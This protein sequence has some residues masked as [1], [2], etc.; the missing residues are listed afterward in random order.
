MATAGRI[1]LLL[2]TVLVPWALSAGED[3]TAR[4][5]VS[6][7]DVLV[8]DWINVRVDITHPR[9]TTSQM[10]LGDTLGGYTVLDRS[11]LTQQAD[12]ITAAEVTVAR[13]DS[14]TSTL[15]PLMFLATV[16]GYTAVRSVETNPVMLTV[17][18]LPVDTARG[19]K[20]IKP[21]LGMPY[22]LAEILVAL[23]IVLLI[24]AVVVLVYRRWKRRAAAPAPAE[25]QAP[26]RPAHLLALEELAI[27]KEKQL[28]QQGWLKEYYTE[29]TEILRRYLERRYTIMALEE[30]SQEIL[31]AVQDLKLP[32]RVVERLENIL[33]RA[34]LV[35]FAK[36]RPELDEH[37]ETMVA[38]REF[39]DRTRPV[40]LSPAQPAPGRK[41]VTSH[42]VS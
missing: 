6:K 1:A 38:A 2:L 13:Y 23:G 8:G 7:S 4:A 29:L 17:R 15:P 35:K 14:G 32:P 20:D 39:V 30:T 27:L 40:T 18:T 25:V 9:G 26:S 41:E 16:P 10:V 33:R 11:P 37:D 24:A 42:V 34:D 31:S 36:H 3:I 28:W 21:P 22:T 12:T 5:S 19:I